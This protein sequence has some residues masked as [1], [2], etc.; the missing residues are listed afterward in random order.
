MTCFIEF[1]AKRDPHMFLEMVSHV[2]DIP[3]PNEG[4]GTVDPTVVKMVQMLGQNADSVVKTFYKTGSQ[5][6]GIVAKAR[7]V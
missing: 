4:K 5:Y 6:K 1:S 3:D 7:K 2:E